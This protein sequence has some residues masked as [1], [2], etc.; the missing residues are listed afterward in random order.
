MRLGLEIIATH[1]FGLLNV[2]AE[3]TVA[4]LAPG[5]GISGWLDRQRLPGLILRGSW[6]PEG[7]LSTLPSMASGFLGVA[8]ARWASAPR[9][10]WRL[11]FAGI[12][13]V[14]TGLLTTIVIPIN[15]ELWSA[16]FVLG[17][18]GMG[19]SGYSRVAA[20]WRVLRP[21]GWGKP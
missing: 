3:N 15:K 6:D 12:L 19:G 13:L 18:S 21:P 16:C 5:A 4:S 8:L 11:A 17:R 1:P 9:P 2:G 10:I 7:I 20:A 14:L